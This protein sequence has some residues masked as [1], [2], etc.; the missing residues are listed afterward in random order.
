MACSNH[1]FVTR[2]IRMRRSRGVLACGCILLAAAGCT[3]VSSGHKGPPSPRVSLPRSQEVTYSVSGNQIVD[4]SG[5]D[6][7]PYGITVYGLAYANWAQMSLTDN[8]EINA[9]ARIWHSNTV[10]LQVDP[11][12]ML[13]TSPY[14]SSM[15]ASLDGEVAQAE[16]DN[17]TV[18][19]SAQTERD[20]GI[21]SI[22]MPNDLVQRF[23]QVI[24]T[25]YRSDDRVWF[26]LFNEPRL[27]SP[28]SQDYWSI[29][30]DGGSGY[31]GMQSLVNTVR[32]TGA[33]NIVLAEGIDLAETL[34]GLI[35]LSGGNIAYAVHPYFTR[36]TQPVDWQTNWGDQA[37]EYP[38]VADE[39]GEW[40]SQSDECNF[41]A[42]VLVPQFL[43]YLRSKNIGLIAWALRPPGVL[44]VDPPNYSDPT[45]FDPHQQY[46]CTGAPHANPP[47]GAGSLLMQYFAKYGGT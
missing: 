38:I 34:E 5:H 37:G 4:T 30:H 1:S 8:G 25:H 19:I 15:L 13:E 17:M 6:F 2:V 47:Q 36:T 23:W 21:R 16:A 40:A 39:W 9:A 32:A 45:S 10:R 20:S 14:D 27:Q 42:P 3:N 44:V 7:I 41:N 11:A 43:D 18:I 33:T 31:V 46:T 22:L 26:D 24:A 29:W 28:R 12:A 35:P